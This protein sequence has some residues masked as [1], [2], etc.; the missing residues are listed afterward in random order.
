MATIIAILATIFFGQ[1]ATCQDTGLT[2]QGNYS[3]Y[4]VQFV[5][6]GENAN[7]IFNEF[8]GQNSSYTYTIPDNTGS[9]EF[10][11][12]YVDNVLFGFEQPLLAQDCIDLPDESE[13]Y[14]VFLPIVF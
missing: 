9:V 10:S 1:Y 2:I 3:A 12:F 11:G 8:D 13:S 5:I 6:N 4:N 14:R 7:A